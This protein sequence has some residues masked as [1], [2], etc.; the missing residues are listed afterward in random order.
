MDNHWVNRNVFITGSTGFLGSYLTESLVEKK[1]NVVILVRDWPFRS[2][3]ILSDLHRKTTVVRGEIEDYFLLERVLNEYEIEVVFHLAAQTIVEIANRNPISTFETNIRGTWN[4][5]EACRRNIH[6]KKIIIA[7]SDKAYGSQEELPYDEKMPLKGNH[8]YDVSK[9]CADLIA[10]TYYNTYNLPLCITRCGNFY[11][12]GDINFNRIIPGTI[13]SVIYGEHPIIRSDGSFIRD[14]IY[15]KD[16][17][18][19]YILL[20]EK[21]D[22]NMIHGEA[23][24][25]SNELQITVLDLTKKILSLMGR[26]DLQPIIKNEAKNEIRHQYLSSK[27]AKEVLGWCPEYT[28]DKGLKETI[29]WYQEFFPHK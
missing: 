29:A 16:A 4:L 22:D 2:R 7:S 26:E 3:F 18:S 6:V 24:N 5:L 21:M 11:G 17:V 14:Y 23:F 13:R 27:K 28:P 1:A 8:P 25:F 20:A 9:S 12:G 19:A 15:I 10:Y